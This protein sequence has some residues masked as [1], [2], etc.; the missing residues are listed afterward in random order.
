MP[1]NPQVTLTAGT[2]PGGF[3]P[4]NEQERFNEYAKRLTGQLPG[5]YSTIVFQAAKP[6]VADQDKLWV[7]TNADGT[8]DRSYTF[9]NGIWRSPHAIPPNFTMLYWG[10]IS[11][12]DSFDGG[13]AGTVTAT[14]GPFW[15][16]VTEARGRFPI[17]PDP[18][19][20]L[21][22]T[23]VS[24]KGTGGEELHTLVPGALPDHVHQLVGAN[25]AIQY[26]GGTLAAAFLKRDVAGTSVVETVETSGGNNKAHNNMP[27]Y[28][29]LY[30]LRRTA[31]L[32]YIIP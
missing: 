26:G 18:N 19:K 16:E 30:L 14:A 8:L 29:G 25:L 12:I 23:P 6:S 27:P 13:A 1:T 17:H 15:A 5:S 24:V 32:Y 28:I 9:S 4:V 21:L 3:C 10:D 31:R 2:L 11:S 7:R 22:T 20:V